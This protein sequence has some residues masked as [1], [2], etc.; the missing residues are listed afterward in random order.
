M[1]AD[2]HLQTAQHGYHFMREKHSYGETYHAYNKEGMK[3][4]AV[5]TMH[6]RPSRANYGYP[7]EVRHEPSGRTH[8]T[9]GVGWH[10]QFT[11]LGHTAPLFKPYR[12]HPPHEEHEVTAMFVDRRNRAVGLTLL[13][14]AQNVAVRQTGHGL[15]TPEDLSR[16]SARMVSRLQQRGVIPAEARS[17]VKNEYDWG[18]SEAAYVPPGQRPGQTIDPEEVMAGRRTVRSILRASRPPKPPPKVEQRTLF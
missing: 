11:D 9:H 15:G 16:H 7:Q 1:S 2:E 5:W 13:G 6:Q 17:E 8:I 3:V 4:G 14:M 18:E 10:R 12:Q